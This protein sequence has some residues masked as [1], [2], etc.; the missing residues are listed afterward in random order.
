VAALVPRW[1]NW[2]WNKQNHTVSSTNLIELAYSMVRDATQNVKQWRNGTQVL[3]WSAAGL[4]DAERRFHRI[5][6]YRDIPMLA[7][8]LRQHL[9][10]V[11]REAVH[12]R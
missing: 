3:R 12:I 5:K 10:A 8:R 9:Q 1:H 2:E 7:M 4:L 11:N 6:G